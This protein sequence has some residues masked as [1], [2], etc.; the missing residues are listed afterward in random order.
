M[1]RRRESLRSWGVARLVLALALTSCVTLAALT[2]FSDLSF[3][4][5]KKK[6]LNFNK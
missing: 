6:D 2:D 3:L 4:L 5:C 1:G